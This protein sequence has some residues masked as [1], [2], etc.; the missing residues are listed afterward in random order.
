MI[1]PE[2]YMLGAAAA[3]GLVFKVKT[4]LQLSKAKQDTPVDAALRFHRRY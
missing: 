3:V 2:G 4:R 1:Q